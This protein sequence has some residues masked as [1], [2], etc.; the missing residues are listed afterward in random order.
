MLPARKW[1]H[2]DPVTD[3]PFSLYSS[4]GTFARNRQRHPPAAP[5]SRSIKPHVPP[6]GAFPRVHDSQCD[7]I[8]S[9]RH[10]GILSMNLGPP[11]ALAHDGRQSRR[12]RWSTIEQSG[13]QHISKRQGLS[14]AVVILQLDIFRHRRVSICRY[15]ALSPVPVAT[16]HSQ[17]IPRSQD[18]MAK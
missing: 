8:P 17:V 16:G 12:E 10:L 4:P 5:F 6:R 9:V 7:L 1:Q 13:S 11:G 3:T 14:S 15:A 2:I 18:R